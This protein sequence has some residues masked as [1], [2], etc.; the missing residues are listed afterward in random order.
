MFS[1][2]VR[3]TDVDLCRKRAEEN[4]RRR[5]EEEERLYAAPP[6]PVVRLSEVCVKTQLLICG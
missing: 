2:D 4:E 3:N 1:Q 6:P 5:L